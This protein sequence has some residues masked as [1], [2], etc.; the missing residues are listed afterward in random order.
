MANVLRYNTTLEVLDMSRN[1]ISISGQLA[2]AAILGHNTTLKV[3]R[4][5]HRTPKVI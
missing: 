4:M 2:M 1:S 3:Y 5:L